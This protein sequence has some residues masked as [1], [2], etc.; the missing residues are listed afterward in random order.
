[1]ANGTA[2]LL[3]QRAIRDPG[4]CGFSLDEQVAA[5]DDLVRW[6]E[7]DVRPQGDAV[8]DPAI[9]ADPAFGCRFTLP[10]RE[11]DTGCPPAEVPGPPAEPEGPAEDPAPP[12]E[13]EV[14]A[15]PASPAS[16]AP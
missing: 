5:F 14:P 12:A 11:G 10:L 9:V 16:P 8:L 4:H 2:D 13:A 6:V 3:V 15:S 1:V 7:G